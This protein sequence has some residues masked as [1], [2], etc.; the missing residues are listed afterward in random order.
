MTAR[1]YGRC[2]SAR[3]PMASGDG[4]VVR[5][6]PR[7]NRLSRDQAHA[8]AAAARRFGNGMIDLPA[9]ANL[10]LRGVRTES[11]AALIDAL[12]PLGLIE[13]EG[14]EGAQVPR[15]I[16]VTPFADAATYALADALRRALVTVPDLS[17]KF[18]FMLDSGPA[19]VMRDISADIR[20]ERGA[21]GGLI[22]RATGL[23]QGAAVTEAQAP[24][25][26]CDL[27]RWFVE[28]GGLCDGRG[29]MAQ[30]IARGARPD[31][32][33]RPT[34]TPAPAPMIA[35]APV[36]PGLVPQGALVGLE[37]G[38][39]HADTLDRLAALG[40]LRLTPWRMLLVEG[41]RAM[42]LCPDLDGLITDPGDLRLRV[43]A[44]TGAPGCLQGQGDVRALARRLAPDLAPDKVLHLSGCTKGC[45][46]PGHAD[47]TL[48]A[49]PAGVDLVRGGRAGD[50][51]VRHG[52]TTPDILQL[53]E[54]S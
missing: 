19:P 26:M 15:N 48:V 44:C 25:A 34:H 45:A 47:L 13:P 1:I 20:L 27:A 39:L 33:L 30:V 22:L 51:P 2:P 16:L 46:G 40:P 11:H 52:L 38:L 7:N 5:L 4:L 3:H 43:F 23:E 42:P 29:R 50:A 18:G 31:A 32:A 8:I 36:L 17:H 28:V 37:F 49:T 21:D 6:R 41:L 14:S 24:E 35:N 10:Q 9:R 54:F 53:P 12:V